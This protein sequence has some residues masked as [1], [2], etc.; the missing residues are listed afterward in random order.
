[1]AHHRLPD[2]NVVT[3]EMILPSWAGTKIMEGTSRNPWMARLLVGNFDF[4]Q[5]SNYG[6]L[7]IGHESEA[8][9]HFD[10][11]EPY[12]GDS[13]VQKI[14]EETF[15][16]LIPIS[17]KTNVLYFE[18]KL[19]RTFEKFWDGHPIH[20]DV[21][22]FF[23]GATCLYRGTSPDRPEYTEAGFDGYVQIWTSTETELQTL[24]HCASRAGAIPQSISGKKKYRALRRLTLD[25]PEYFREFG[26][27]WPIM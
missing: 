27:K 18:K 12:R 21:Y 5:E 9:F 22:F 11:L 24:L 23:F 16:F 26:E 1:L 14:P 4:Q 13:P 7:L 17:Q 6:K 25:T 19:R 2:L 8:C 10:Q 15:E 20:H 3:N